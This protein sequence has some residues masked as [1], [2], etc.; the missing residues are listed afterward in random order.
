MRGRVR[1]HAVP[2]AFLAPSLLLL[3]PLRWALGSP[4]EEV[5]VP[6]LGANV[7]WILGT[8]ALLAAALAIACSV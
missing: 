2:L 3:G 6:A 7:G 1:G 5:P 4:L 8:N